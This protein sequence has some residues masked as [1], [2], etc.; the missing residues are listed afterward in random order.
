MLNFTWLESS[1]AGWGLHVPADVGRSGVWQRGEQKGRA[2]DTIPLD[3][4]A[5]AGTASV[6]SWN[7]YA[8]K[9]NQQKKQLADDK[10]QPKSSVATYMSRNTQKQRI[11]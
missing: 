7:L 3:P 1:L 10:A 6:E 5:P 9:D 8:I 11:T 4:G 2:F